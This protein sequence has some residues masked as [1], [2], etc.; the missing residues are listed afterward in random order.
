MS[1]DEMILQMKTQI[2]ELQ[3]KIKLMET[4]KVS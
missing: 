1:T 3:E 4:E 2:K